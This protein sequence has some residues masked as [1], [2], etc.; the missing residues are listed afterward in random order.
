M[1]NQQ[2]YNSILGDIKKISSRNYVTYNG[3]VNGDNPWLDTDIKDAELPEWAA[4]QMDETVLIID[5]EEMVI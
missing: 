1:S 4:V 5:G 3:G 2:L